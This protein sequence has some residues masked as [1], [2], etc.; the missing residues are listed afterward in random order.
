[1]PSAS[2]PPTRASFG[3]VPRSRASPDGSS[4]PPENRDLSVVFQELALWPHLTV[5]H[6]LGFGLEA[7][8]VPRAVR[9][10]QVNDMLQQVGLDDKARR[11]PGQLSGGE[12]Q[13][14]AIARALVLR[15]R[16]VL[17]DEPLTNLDVVLRRDL[18]A[19]LHE[20]L[21]DTGSAALYVTHDLDERSPGS[22][23]PRRRP[24]QDARTLPRCGRA[25]DRT[26]RSPLGLVGRDRHP[27]RG[28]PPVARTA[29]PYQAGDR[30][31][32]RR[33]V[34]PP[35]LHRAQP[36]GHPRSPVAGHRFRFCL[37][38]RPRGQR[39]DTVATDGDGRAEQ[40]P[41]RPLR[42]GC[43]K[44]WCDYQPPV[45]RGERVYPEPTAEYPGA[46]GIV[47]NM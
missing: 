16:A 8:G 22:G 38:R 29:Q 24:G 37:R 41:R 34:R 36:D 30:G 9:R 5:E 27:R 3:S 2:S 32:R 14:V 43:R 33:T 12:R 35:G 21:T 18:F 6:N 44:T 26:L 23:Q 39:P 31:H 46:G 10:S 45:R 19:V 42:R 47:T 15:P 13:R 11:Y 4:I 20:L 17:L 25:K 40:P 7:K 1:M 28:H